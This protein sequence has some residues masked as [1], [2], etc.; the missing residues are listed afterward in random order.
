[1]KPE[2]ATK[3]VEARATLNALEATVYEEL[4]IKRWKEL[5]SIAKSAQRLLKRED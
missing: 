4:E 1:M 2:L 3:M 5:E